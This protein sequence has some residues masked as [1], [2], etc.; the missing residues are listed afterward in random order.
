MENTF[1]R[2]VVELHD[3]YMEVRPSGLGSRA[4][5]TLTVSVDLAAHPSPAYADLL[6]STRHA[7]ASGIAPG[8][9]CG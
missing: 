2:E 8:L 5:H 9:I 4:W 1:M 6:Y 3:K 7:A